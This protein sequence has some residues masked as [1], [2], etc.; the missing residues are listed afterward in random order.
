MHL[1]TCWTI[2]TPWTNLPECPPAA[3]VLLWANLSQRTVTTAAATLLRRFPGT[4]LIGCST[5]GLVHEGRLASSGLLAIFWYTRHPIQA[6]RARARGLANEWSLA[7]QLAAAIGGQPTGP[8]LLL[9][10]GLHL[11]GERLAEALSSSLPGCPMVGGMA[12]DGERFHRTSLLWGEDIQEDGLVALVF[13]PSVESTWA[14]GCGWHPIGPPRTVTAA[15]GPLVLEIDKEPAL[16]L[17]SRYLGPHAADL[18]ASGH[19]FPLLVTPPGSKPR[20]RSLIAVAPQRQGLRFTTAIPE[21]STVRLMHASLPDVLAEAQAT[22]ARLPSGWEAALMV[23]C[24]ARR[25]V[26]GPLA[27]DEAATV[28]QTLGIPTIGWYSYG[29]ITPCPCT[30]HNQTLCL[31]LFREQEG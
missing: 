29:E 1:E 22:A 13:P 17:Y 5:A 25:H 6:I 10:E 12:G 28:T 15:Q 23:S 20:L 2:D 19:H 21:G 9:C 26:L 16:E 8:V 31:T 4:A 11:D 7:R 14:S 18:P 24:V 3:L 27:D 30:F